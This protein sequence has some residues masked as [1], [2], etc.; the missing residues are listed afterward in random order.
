MKNRTEQVCQASNSKIS[1][2]ASDLF[3]DSGRRMLRSLI[4]GQRDPGWMADYARGKLRN[5]KQE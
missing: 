3:G 5:K 4:E 2:V 1:S